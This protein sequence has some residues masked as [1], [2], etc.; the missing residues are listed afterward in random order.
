[1]AQSLMA[2]KYVTIVTIA[3]VFVPI[4]C[5]LELP[6]RIPLMQCRKAVWLMVN[7]IIV[8]V[9]LMPRYVKSERDIFLYVA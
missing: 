5:F 9:L 8:L 7:A 4:T 3:C 2:C 6:K 1:M